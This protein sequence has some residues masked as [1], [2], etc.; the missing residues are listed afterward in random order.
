MKEPDYRKDLVRKALVVKK[1]VEE[2]NGQLTLGD[3]EGENNGDGDNDDDLSSGGGGSRSIDSTDENTST[4]VVCLDPFRVGDVVAWS[5]THLLD[6]EAAEC[7]HIFHRECIVSWLSQPTHDDCPSYMA[8]IVQEEME[9]DDFSE[10]EPETYTDSVFV[11][12]HGLVSRVRRASYSLIGQSID[13]EDGEM[14][15]G[16]SGSSNRR[17]PKV[18]P[19]PIRRVFS[20]EGRPQTR[21]PL[22]SLRRRPSDRSVSS[23]SVSLV[24]T[25]EMDTRELTPRSQRS[26]RL[27]LSPQLLRRV[28]SDFAQSP[29]VPLTRTSSL[30]RRVS[31]RLQPRGQDYESVSTHVSDGHS[32]RSL[33]TSEQSLDEEEEDLVIRYVPTR[34]KLGD[35]DSNSVGRNEM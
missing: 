9:E 23:Q 29:L 27:G 34:E 15:S 4:C 24:E 26:E 31:R 10:G 21:Y 2:I 18:P 20:L 30:S 25:S 33:D 3:F 28:V 13:F 7:H 16:S 6:P 8:I 11:I 17:F 12:M 19:S 22:S 32:E 35:S 1:V 5:R 14:D